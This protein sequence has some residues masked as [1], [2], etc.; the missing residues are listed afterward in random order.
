[1]RAIDPLASHAS[2]MENFPWTRIAGV[3]VP[4][5]RKPMVDLAHL[6]LLDPVETRAYLGEGNF[7]GFH[8]RS[9]ADMEA[10]W[11]VAVEETRAK[12]ADGW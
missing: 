7:G 11:K 8:Q 5:E 3:T 2:W 9:D 4:D 10:I 12:L 1:V 6:K